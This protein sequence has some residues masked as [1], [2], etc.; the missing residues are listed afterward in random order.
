M[1]M[2]LDRSNLRAWM[3]SELIPEGVHDHDDIKAFAKTYMARYA[4]YLSELSDDAL[5]EEANKL[6]DNYDEAE[7]RG[8]RFYKGTALKDL[9]YVLPEMDRRGL[10][11]QG[12]PRGP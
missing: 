2:R 8:S 7:V 1:E 3:R 10:C 5:E 9:E 12:F 6:A 4:V 11:T